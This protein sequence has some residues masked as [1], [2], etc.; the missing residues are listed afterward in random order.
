[1]NDIADH[2]TRQNILSLLDPSRRN[3]EL[4]TKSLD[5]LKK[6]LND[7]TNVLGEI[8]H[9]Q[10][11]EI[12]KPNPMIR[13]TSEIVSIKHTLSLK[14][15][16][17][18]HWEQNLLMREDDLL[19]RER[20]LEDREQ[21]LKSG[22]AKSPTRDRN[23]STSSVRPP[24]PVYREQLLPSFDEYQPYNYTPTGILNGMPNQSL[25]HSNIFNSSND[26]SSPINDI[27]SSM[28]PND[29]DEDA[30]IREAI[31]KSEMDALQSFDS[32]Q[33]RLLN[34]ERDEIERKRKE[35]QEADRKANEENE[36]RIK[37]EQLNVERA[38]KL[39]EEAEAKR[40]EEEFSASKY[41]LE[42]KPLKATD[43]FLDNFV[44]ML[45]SKNFKEI[46]SYM[47]TLD[48]TTIQWIIKLKYNGTTFRQHLA[49]SSD[50]I[51]KCITQ[52]E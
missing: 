45:K 10:Y 40:K 28:I 49:V 27:I 17:L 29:Y 2:E 51:Y 1:M 33:E 43:D 15:Q 41:K 5:E 37:E 38:R 39:E 26:L 4:A 12:Y 46:R 31:L 8:T 35:E 25:A 18:L 14:E 22:R 20:E 50:E 32:A 44:K 16:K 52:E 36:R 47:T 13:A 42:N 30:A 3:Q 21:R 7:K 9:E 23:N 48:A 34:R 19:R 6:M 24:D 11:D